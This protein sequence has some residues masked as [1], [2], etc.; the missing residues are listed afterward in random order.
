MCNHK[1]DTD[2]LK[3]LAM[4]RQIELQRLKKTEV[5]D[6]GDSLQSVTSKQ[7]QLQNDVQLL[8]DKL[9]EKV[10]VSFSFA[11]SIIS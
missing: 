10:K 3:M 6:L 1:E 4:S 5:D 2:A 8:Q 9:V 11:S 7:M